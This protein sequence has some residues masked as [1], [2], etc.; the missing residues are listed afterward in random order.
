MAWQLHLWGW[1][2]MGTRRRKRRRSRF[3]SR[4]QGRMG[5]G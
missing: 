4:W 1:V 2:R 3:S 5:R